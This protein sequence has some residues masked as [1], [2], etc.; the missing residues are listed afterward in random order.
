M[1][2]SVDLA[3][4]LGAGVASRTSTTPPPAAQKS[5]NSL[6][7]DDFLMLMVAQ[8]QNQTIDNTADSSDMLNQLVQMSVVEAIT[9]I[10]DA[11]VM[12]YA[13]SLVGKEVTVGQY[14]NGTLEE[15]VGVVTGTGM[16]GGQQVIFV[17]G[18]SYYLSDI[19][20]VGRLPAKPDPEK[21][22]GGEGE[23]PEGGE[24]VNPEGGEEPKPEAPEPPP[25]PPE[26]G[27]T[28]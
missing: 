4:V 26:S 18:K 6:D 27:G 9:N 25:A 21:P 22:D 24:G 1:S 13:G 5:G 19:M 17:N 2:N 8:F 11:A 14:N 28:R 15:I 12:M 3:G 7:M 10:T 23:K 20:A 16:A